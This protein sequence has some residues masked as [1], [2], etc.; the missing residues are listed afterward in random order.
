VIGL[1]HLLR[2]ADVKMYLAAL[3]PRRLHQPIDV[4]AHHGRF[5]R[6]G[7]HEFE[8]GEFGIGLLARFLGHARRLDALLEFADL[9]RRIVEFA[10]F[11]LNGLHLLI[12]VVL[13]LA[14][15]HLLLDAATNAFF[16]LQHIHFA[17]DHG[18]HVFQTLAH[19]GDF[20]N[21]LLF[22]KLQRHV[23]RNRIGQAS[24]CSMPASDVRISGGTFLLSFTY[25]SN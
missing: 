16:D 9:I 17:F 25:C 10:E 1:E 19:V 22:G 2:G 21:F 20:E 23:G 7:R 8:L 18:E 15:L 3:F 14:F 6:H 4:I 12:Q 13:A 24:C 5:R 11:L